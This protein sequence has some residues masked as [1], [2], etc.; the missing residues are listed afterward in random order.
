MRNRDLSRLS[1]YRALANLLDSLFRVPGTKLRFGLDPILGLLPGAGDL[2]T[3][4]MGGYGLVVAAQ[5]GAPVS[6]Q[7]RMLFNLLV[8]AAVGAVPIVGD[9]FDFAFKA[10][11]RNLRL[12]EDWTG[13]PHA[14]RRSSILLLF[15]ILIVFIGCV[16]GVIWVV[17][18]LLSGLF[19]LVSSAG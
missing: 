18:L 12:L 19:H 17:W 2:A 1:R 8:D 7:L 14:T 15:V 9:L 11:I 10:H 6:I 4:V 13:Q 16:A 3:A 5:L